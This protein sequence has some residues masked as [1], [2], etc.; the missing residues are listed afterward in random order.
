VNTDATE[1]TIEIVHERGQNRPA[2]WATD[3]IPVTE[4]TLPNGQK[5]LPANDDR[6]WVRVGKVDDFPKEGG[7]AVRYGYAQLAV[8]RFSSR[9]EWYA[10]SNMCPHKQEFV[11][12][13]GIIGDVQGEPKVACPLHKKS[14]SLKT[15][16]CLTGEPY[17]IDTFPVKI[18]GDDVLLFVPPPGKL[19]TQTAIEQRQCASSC[20]HAQECQPVVSLT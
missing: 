16:N 14:F 4:L 11:L 20:H 8:F 7:S 17:S 6:T 5:Y 13:R 9:D 3:T 12:A 18:E 10:T 2:D 15:G 19:A 1:P